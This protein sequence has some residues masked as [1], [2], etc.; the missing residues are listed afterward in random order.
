MGAGVTIGMKV[1]TGVGAKAVMK[2]RMGAE[3]TIGMKVEAK[4]GATTMGMKV[5]VRAG[6]KVWKG[7]ASRRGR[8][9]T[10]R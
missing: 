3:A 4:A 7:V 2:A 8:P 5:E 10:R 1:R 6:M 9:W